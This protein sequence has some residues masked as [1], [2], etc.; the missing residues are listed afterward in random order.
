MLNAY[1]SDDDRQDDGDTSD[2]EDSIF[3]DT[4]PPDSVISFDDTVIF[5]N[6]AELAAGGVF[7]ED[8]S[9]LKIDDR[10]VADLQR[11]LDCRVPGQSRS[12]QMKN[13]WNNTIARGGQENLAGPSKGFC[14]TVLENAMSVETISNGG[15]YEMSAWKSGDAFPAFRIVMQ[16]GFGNKF[17]PTNSSQISVVRSTARPDEAYNT[18]VPATLMSKVDK[19]F[20]DAFIQETA[21]EDVSS[22]SAVIALGNRYAKPGDYQLSIEVK[23][24][25]LSA[26]TILVEVR[27][28]R[29]N[30]KSDPD[31]MVCRSCGRKEYNFHPEDLNSICADCPENADCSTRFILPQADHWNPFPC[32][33]HVKRCIQRKACNQGDTS[34][35]GDLTRKQMSCEFDE[36][37]LLEY[38]SS[39]CADGHQGVLCGA[40]ENS[41]V[42]G[43]QSECV[44][45]IPTPAAAVALAGILTMQV[46]LALLQINET[47]SS[48]NRNEHV[49]GRSPKQGRRTRR[50]LHPLGRYESVH[51]EQETEETPTSVA[52]NLEETHRS[53]ADEITK[54]KWSFLATLKVRFPTSDRAL[55]TRMLY[56]SRLILYKLW[57]S[58]L[59]WTWIGT[60]PLCH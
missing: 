45:C 59:C 29:I 21:Q 30:E 44:E 52:T 49:G 55:R 9:L 4:R 33:D 16:D 57:L 38:Q 18:S 58:L 53:M 13:V 23:G 34:A 51:G 24:F 19:D 1:V 54:A 28:C 48:D 56:R 31:E 5:E 26:V 6:K 41:T 14:V 25:E 43:T 2:A 12:T 36:D 39:Q 40:C 37:Y 47:L 35:L 50:T 46:I 32:S 27:G 22:G 60:Y 10:D 7:V 42:R 8:A 3:E 17:S 20:P 15:H 11:E